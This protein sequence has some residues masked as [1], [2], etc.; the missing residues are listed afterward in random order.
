MLKVV[1]LILIYIIKI[2]LESSSGKNKCFQNYRSLQ[3]FSEAL[4]VQK[5]AE[6]VE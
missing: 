2:S 4:A 3:K 6:N 5:M 1:Q